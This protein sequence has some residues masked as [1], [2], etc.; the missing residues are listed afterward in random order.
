MIDV[1]CAAAVASL[2]V[3]RETLVEE[4]GN[5]RPRVL[6]GIRGTRVNRTSCGLL[7]A[8]RALPRGTA[9]RGTVFVCPPR[10]GWLADCASKFE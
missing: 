2:A 3:V 10:A 8:I 7:L 5:R 6:P 9:L 1:R 4:R